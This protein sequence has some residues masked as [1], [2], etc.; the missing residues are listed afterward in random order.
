MFG[1]AVEFEDDGV[2]EKE[3]DAVALHLCL[4]LPAGDAAEEELGAGE[5]LHGGIGVVDRGAR[6][7]ARHAAVADAAHALDV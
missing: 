7:V 1:V 6:G 5:G 4:E 3:V 2:V